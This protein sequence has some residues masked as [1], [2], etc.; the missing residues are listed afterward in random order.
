MAD[1]NIIVTRDRESNVERFAS[2]ALWACGIAGTA[3][4]IKLAALLIGIEPARDATDSASI[5]SGMSLYTDYGTGCQYL[6]RDG[7][8]TPRLGADGKQVCG[9]RQ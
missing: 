8:L 1:L 5:R 9:A 6:G 3:T 2:I 7:A 4:I